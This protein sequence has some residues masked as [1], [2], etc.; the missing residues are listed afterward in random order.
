[1]RAITSAS[2]LLLLPL[3]TAAQEGPDVSR[4]R[5]LYE[6]HCA[7]CHTERLHTRENS[8][9]RSYGAL[10]A[11]V[12]RRAALTNRRFSPDELE[13]IIEYLDRSHYR[14]DLPLPPRRK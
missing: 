7:T 5:L 13:D 8:I 3:A 2:L 14:L 4:G 1:M 12:V 10:R 6:T 11:E 9:I